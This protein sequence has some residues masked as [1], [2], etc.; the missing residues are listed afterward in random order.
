MTTS[1]SFDHVVPIRTS[2]D[3]LR[4][5]QASREVGIALGFDEEDQTR[6]ATAVSEIARNVLQHSGATGEVRLQ[7]AV[8][9]AGRGI[10]VVVSDSGSGI[11]D[12]DGALQDGGSS[13]VLRRGA[14][15][16]GSKRLMDEF[17]VDTAVGKGT[18]VRMV[19]WIRPVRGSDS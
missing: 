5:R 7:D 18:T 17:Q 12:L 6:I 2:E 4:A 11:A 15:L 14:G 13:L 3:V 19:K 8:G 9:D 1:S 16:P 10:V